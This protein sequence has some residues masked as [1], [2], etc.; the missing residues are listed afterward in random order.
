MMGNAGMVLGAV[1]NPKHE[2]VKTQRKICLSSSVQSTLLGAVVGAFFFFCI[3]GFVVLDV[4]YDDWIRNATGDFAQSYYGWKFY[5]AS[6]WHWPIGLMDGVADPS[7][8][9]I[10]YIDSVPLFDVFFKILSPILP[11]TF[12]FFG[13]WGLCCF[14]LD[15]AIGAR[16]VF[17][18]TNNVIYSTFASVFF[19]LTTFSIQRLYTHTALAA[20]WVILLG[21]L[22]IITNNEGRSIIKH[23]LL[24]CGLFFLAISVNM[25]YV[26]I[27]GILMVLE[28][29]YLV[30]S[31]KCTVL[32]FSELCAS[33]I[34]AVLA[35]YL[36]GGFYHISGTSVNGGGLGRLGANLNALL[37]PME[38]GLYLTGWSKFIK[39]KP[40]AVLGQY[41]GYSYLGLGLIAL[42][43]IAA[44]GVM[45]KGMRWIKNVWATAH[46]KIVYVF[47]A[48]ALLMVASFGTEVTLN[49][50]TLFHIPYPDFFLKIYGIFRSTGRFMWGV[51]DILAILAF[52]VVYK[53]FS[54]KVAA[55]LLIAC[56]LLQVED[57]SPM[58]QDRSQLYKH[59]Q[60]TYTALIKPKNLDPLLTGKK[61]VLF[62]G[63]KQLKFQLYYDVAEEAIPRSV[64]LNDFY[65]S[66]RDAIAIKKYKVQE[67]KKMSS[68]IFDKDTLYV[69][70]SFKEGLKF[71]DSLH[72]YY[73]SG[74]LWGS[75]S[76]VPGFDEIVE[77][78]PISVSMSEKQIQVKGDADY[79]GLQFDG[80][81]AGFVSIKGDK[82]S[83]DVGA[84]LDNGRRS[85]GV[86]KLSRSSV[87]HLQDNYKC[88]V[89][90]YRL[91]VR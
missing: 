25:Y 88:H 86:T 90:G 74:L 3:Y 70:D 28:V 46:V 53:T 62:M 69:F 16:I 52:T 20:N 18:L 10:M 83:D 64:T 19:T 72:L 89:Q 59:K 7:L 61:H 27:I 42:L 38:T 5:R 32:G 41:E 14:V 6:D 37:N 21:I 68:G 78:S 58:L 73:F 65:Y 45:A 4:T 79:V 23:V 15:G 67:R 56:L 47:C 82:Q 60:Q 50:R 54:N 43:S 12:Q 66:R 81:D 13:I 40:V 24:W 11:G 63:D 31:Q 76:A 30:F 17:Q 22:L 87:V 75:T 9:P 51:W 39:S 71:Q 2:V 34:G 80:N 57:L 49:G 85:L 1:M 36:Y 44:V 35:F 8:T 91:V 55:I 29:I 77:I 33:M 26:P 48:I 84:T